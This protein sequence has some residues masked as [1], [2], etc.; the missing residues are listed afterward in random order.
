MLNKVYVARNIL[1]E[2]AKVREK[3]KDSM[4]SSRAGG[5]SS[6]N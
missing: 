2:I 5:N 6:L 4:C 3:Q 1:V